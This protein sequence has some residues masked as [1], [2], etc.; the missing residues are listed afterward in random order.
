MPLVACIPPTWATSSTA[1]IGSSGYSPFSSLDVWTPRDTATIIASTLGDL[2]A[3]W[4][5]VL[6]DYEGQ[7]TRDPEKGAPFRE[8]EEKRSLRGLV[9]AIY[10]QP[11][12]GVVMTGWKID[13]VFLLGYNEETDDFLALMPKITATEA[14]LLY[15]LLSRIFV[16]DIMKR[17]TAGEILADP[18]FHMD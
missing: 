3:E 2:P 12:G 14:D 4:G 9:D 11:E 6:F 17:L 10:D 8:L 1:A 7:P 13:D 5:D 16:Y 18:W 15:G